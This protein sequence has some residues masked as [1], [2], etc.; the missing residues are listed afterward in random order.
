MNSILSRNI[1]EL[2]D[3]KY[4][5]LVT[6][7]EDIFLLDLKQFIDFLHNNELIKPF[8]EKLYREV[9]RHLD[10]Y[11]NKLAVEMKEAIEIKNLLLEQYL[12]MDDRNIERP[13]SEFDSEDYEFSFAEFENI[14]RDNRSDFG[15][16]LYTPG[17]YEDE[18]DVAKLIQILRMKVSGYEG[19]D[20]KS[21]R[22]IDETIEYKLQDLESLHK[23]T[24]R[25]WKNYQRTSPGRALIELAD[26]VQRINKEPEDQTEWRKKSK[27]E[28]LNY[29]FEKTFTRRNYSW[30]YISVYGTD[31]FRNSSQIGREDIQ[32]YIAKSKEL[33]KRVYEGVRQE[34]GTTQIY[35]QLLNRYSLRSQWYNHSFLRS[36]VA[37]SRGGYQRN[38]EDLLTK[39]LALF[40]F[41]NGVTAQYRIRFGKHEFDLLGVDIEDPIFIEAKAYKDS[42]AKRE[43]IDGIA[44]LHSYL[45]N[46]EGYKSIHEAYYVVY[47]LA[48]PIYEFPEMVN[49]NRFTIFPILVDLGLSQESGRKQPKP[50]LVKEEEILSKLEQAEAKQKRKSK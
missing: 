23:H 14:E 41:D 10:N 50:I 35:L 19:L 5:F 49:T 43:L 22:R 3:R 40:L 26:I 39:D 25:E 15:K 13:A 36:L 38:R 37:S 32:K 28:K 6:V 20:E 44:Q 16:P 7:P 27:I 46:I 9:K 21:K 11:R 33:L 47:R 12:E 30:I 8:A 24:H 48:G 18:S 4:S 1:V 29:A 17:I 34:I 45:S 42:G 2:L 31:S